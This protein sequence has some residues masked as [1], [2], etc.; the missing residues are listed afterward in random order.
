MAPKQRPSRTADGQA[1]KRARSRYPEEPNEEGLFVRG[2]EVKG[3]WV[4]Q[5]CNCSQC[6]ESGEPAEAFRDV[7]EAVAHELAALGDR[8]KTWSNL[9]K[10]DRAL[11]AFVAAEND[12]SRDH[13]TQE[14]DRAIS[15]LSAT[16]PGSTYPSDHAVI[17]NELERGGFTATQLLLLHKAAHLVPPMRKDAKDKDV[18]EKVKYQLAMSLCTAAGSQKHIV[19]GEQVFDYRTLDAW[20]KCQKSQLP[21]AEW[22]PAVHESLRAPACLPAGRKRPADVSREQAVG[23]NSGAAASGGLFEGIF[24]TPQRASMKQAAKDK[25]TAF[26]N[27]PEPQLDAWLERNAMDTKGSIDNKVRRLVNAGIQPD[28]APTEAG[29]VSAGSAHSQHPAAPTADAASGTAP[30]GEPQG[31]GIMDLRKK[32]KECNLRSWVVA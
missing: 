10:E 3:R 21:C 24:G 26:K 11:G 23:G 16:M 5:P 27:M 8:R 15:T 31:K 18:P 17:H 6:L 14:V 28:A 9:K 30:G 2:N 25:E 20:M 7:E 4:P 22:S 32:L 1:Q 12:A 19:Q 13:V 29:A